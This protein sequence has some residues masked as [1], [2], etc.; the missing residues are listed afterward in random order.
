MLR[1][2]GSDAIAS[3]GVHLGRRVALL[4][5][6]LLFGAMTVGVSAT[7]GVTSL[8][9]WRLLAGIGLALWGRGAER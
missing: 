6:M 8:A 2:V 7:D 5:S 9:V 1:L 3:L 4:G